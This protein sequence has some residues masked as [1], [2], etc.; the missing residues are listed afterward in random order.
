LALIV[1]LVAVALYLLAARSI[2]DASIAIAHA[3][4]ARH[5]Q[6]GRFGP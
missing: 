1:V 4:S 5:D 2:R 3:R 6:H